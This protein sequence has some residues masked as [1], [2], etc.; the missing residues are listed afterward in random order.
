MLAIVAYRRVK[1][2]LCLDCKALIDV[3]H[4]SPCNSD[5]NEHLHAHDD[6]VWCFVH[7]QAATCRTPRSTHP[8]ARLRRAK[9]GTAFAMASAQ[10]RSRERQRSRDR[11]TWLRPRD[12][13][14]AYN[15]NTS[16][17]LIYSILIPLILYLG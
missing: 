3:L 17:E 6:H 9:R 15:N 4:C 5:F 13:R 1:M 11:E 2:A 8:D 7:V 10:V 16:N 14:L 12:P